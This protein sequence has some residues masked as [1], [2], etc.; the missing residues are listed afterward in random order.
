MR[1]YFARAP[2]ATAVGSDSV[3]ERK[4]KQKTKGGSC[5]SRGNISLNGR[6]FFNRNVIVIFV[7]LFCSPSCW[8]LPAVIQPFV[9][10]SSTLRA[11]ACTGCSS[12]NGFIRRDSVCPQEKVGGSVCCLLEVEKHLVTFCILFRWH[13]PGL[14]SLH[15]CSE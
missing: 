14:Q 1:I 11:P 6:V 8:L 3:W 5:W 13:P 10:L 2:E 15:I 9:T 4:N 7:C 12:I